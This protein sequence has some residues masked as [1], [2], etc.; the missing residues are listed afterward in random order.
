MSR[1]RQNVESIRSPLR[2]FEFEFDAR[3]FAW[4]NA[5]KSHL[6]SFGSQSEANDSNG[7]SNNNRRN[8]NNNNNYERQR[9]RMKQSK[10]R[11][12]IQRKSINVQ[13]AWTKATLPLSMESSAVSQV[14]RSV[15]QQLPLS[16]ALQFVASGTLYSTE[17]DRER[18]TMD[19][20]IFIIITHST[21][22][23][24]CFVICHSHSLRHTAAAAATYTAATCSSSSSSTQQRTVAT[25][26]EK[27]D[28]SHIQFI[29][30]QPTKC[31]NKTK[32]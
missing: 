25:C 2:S 5:E 20:E 8:N 17:R 3:P 10:W 15:E 30:M 14:S 13:L 19:N 16:L 28:I 24:F 29:Y 7:N 18:D 6:L 23:G 26:S 22:T 9:Q 4:A 21:T 12:N 32:N 1:T 11:Q 31:R 27:K